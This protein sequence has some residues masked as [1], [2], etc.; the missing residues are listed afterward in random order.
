MAKKPIVAI[1]GASGF[2]G[3]Q[4]VERF[5]NKG[6]QVVALVRN[7]AERHQEG[8]TFVEYDVSKPLKNDILK[9]VDYLIHAAY[10]KAVPGQADDAFSLN[11]R[12]AERI[13]QVSRAAKVKRNVFISSL[14]AK[15]DATSSYGQQKYAIE[16]LFNT[17]QDSIV[18]PGLVI[19]NGGLAKDMI[20]FIRTKRIVP[21][22]GGG[23]QAIQI[24]AVADLVTAIEQ[25]LD[26]NL[27]GTYTVAH[28]TPITYREFYES[29]G[30]YIKVKPLFIPI[31]LP[32]LLFTIRAAHR[33]RLPLSVTEDNLLGLSKI[34]SVATTKDLKKLGLT[35]R[36]L[37]T[38]LADSKV[39]T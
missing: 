29:I 11:L 35:L 14:S 2:I 34:E 12:G 17:K 32:F 31:S 36:P 18:R 22:I 13:L 4:L 37:D 21:L 30:T 7:A 23:K 38:A 9:N 19:G 8:V 16:Q 27:A 39:A 5:K 6:W 33:L 26:K 1:T 20:Q 28:N 25:I 3:S 15:S 24:V 10:I